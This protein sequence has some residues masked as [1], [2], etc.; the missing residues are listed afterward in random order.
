[1][2]TPTTPQAQTATDLITPEFKKDFHRDYL[3]RYFPNSKD[4]NK[5]QLV[6]LKRLAEIVGDPQVLKNLFFRLE[7]NL[8]DRL[9]VSLRRGI[10][11]V[12]IVR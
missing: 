12:F 10:R 1:M 3:V 9:D 11:F 6:G 4:R 2:K 5:N 8:N 7:H